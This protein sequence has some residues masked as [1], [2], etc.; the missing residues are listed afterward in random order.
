MILEATRAG[1]AESGGAIEVFQSSEVAVV[2]CQVFD[3]S[4]R[5]LDLVDVKN[6]RVSNC[7]VLDRR[8]PAG[9]REAIRLGGQ[10]SR[11]LVNDNLVSTGTEGSLSIAPNSAAVSGNIVAEVR[12]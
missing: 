3:P 10:S 1:D 11:N 7:T 4:V 2:G 8:E 12:P 9:M 6:S 5:G